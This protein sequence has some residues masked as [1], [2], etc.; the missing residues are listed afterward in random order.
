LRAP[1]YAEMF[2]VL[3]Y[4]TLVAQAKAGAPR[5]AL[6]EAVPSELLEAVCAI[7]SAADVRDRIA[8]Y[9]R[10]GADH[11]GIAPSTADD[12]A[13]RRVLAAVG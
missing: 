9:H 13:G 4:E 12:P 10:V 11:V 7:G 6:A 2:S 8:E 5:R 1:G 3:G